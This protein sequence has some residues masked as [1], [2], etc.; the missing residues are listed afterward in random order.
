LLL[1]FA[2]CFLLFWM[3]QVRR[4]AWKIN[5]GTTAVGAAGLFYAAVLSG[6]VGLAT[7][8]LCCLGGAVFTGLYRAELE[9]LAAYSLLRGLSRKRSL[10]LELENARRELDQA[11][12]RV[13]LKDQAGPGPAGR[14]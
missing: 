6:P 14:S 10:E 3:G 9:R 12:M 8:L 4:P 1:V 11:K 13:G 2:T 5:L 7:V